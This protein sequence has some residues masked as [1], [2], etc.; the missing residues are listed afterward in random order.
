MPNNTFDFGGIS[1]VFA[2]S[3]KAVS[4]LPVY[5]GSVIALSEAI[6]IVEVSSGK[7]HRILCYPLVLKS[8]PSESSRGRVKL[9]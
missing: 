5:V 8:T 3:N 1:P 2:I 9:T 7:L 4:A 6:L